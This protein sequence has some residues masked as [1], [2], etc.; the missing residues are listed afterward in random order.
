MACK[1]TLTS[2]HSDKHGSFVIAGD[3]PYVTERHEFNTAEQAR[4][5]FASYVAS[6]TATGKGAYCGGHVSA[7]RG[8]RL[9]RGAKALDLSQWVNV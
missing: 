4:R 5:L 3:S 1:L 7:G 2:F 8:E 6:V 9:P